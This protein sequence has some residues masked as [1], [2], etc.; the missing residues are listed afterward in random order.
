MGCTPLTVH[1][2]RPPPPGASGL[3]SFLLTN[4]S[5]TNGLLKELQVSKHI[6]RISAFDNVV[7][8]F[9]VLVGFIL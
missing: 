6:S 9:Q 1:S 7:V 3:R 5:W 4:P 8:L 2:V